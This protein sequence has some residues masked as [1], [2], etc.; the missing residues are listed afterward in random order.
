VS[1]VRAFWIGAAGILVLA[2][3]LSQERPLIDR[4]VLDEC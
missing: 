2:C 3:N 4:N 1:L